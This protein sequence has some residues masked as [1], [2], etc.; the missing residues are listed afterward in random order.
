MALRSVLN[1]KLVTERFCALPFWGH[2][3]GCSRWR[4]SAWPTACSPTW[5]VDRLTVWQ[6]AASRESLQVI[7]FGTAITL[8]AIIGY[9]VFAYRVFRGKASELSYG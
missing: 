8:P 6:A 9:T 3:R 5:V 4:A 1:S 7:L 2:G